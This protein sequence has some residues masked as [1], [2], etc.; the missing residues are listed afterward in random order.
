MDM[1]SNLALGLD[2]AFAPINL[3]ST[4]LGCL[5]GTLVGVLPGMGTVAILAMLLPAI[6]ALPPLAALSMLAGVYYGAPYG[7]ATAALWVKQ[8]GATGSVLTRIDGY[9]M[10]RQ[11][12]A[13]PALAAAGLGAFLAGCFGTLVLAA[14][15]PAL[16][17]LAFQLEPTEY[18][19][20]MVLALVGAGVLA[21]GALLKALAMGVLGLLLGLV[22]T[23]VHFGLARFA[24]DVPELSDGIGVVT[25]AMGVFAYG[26]V[27]SKLA[28]SEPAREVFT[29]Q[30]PD[31]WPTRQDLKDMA[32]AVLRGSALGSLLGMAPGG[33]A[34]LASFAAY[35]LEKKVQSRPGEVP[36]GKGNIRGVAAPEAARNA[37]AQTA[38]TA[39]LAL[40]IPPNAALAL[41]VGALS[42]HHIPPGPQLLTSNPALFW[43][44]IVSLCLG[45]LMLWVLHLPRIG[46]WN[47]LLSVPYRW[48][49]PAVVLLCAMGVYSSTHSRFDIWLV[50]AFGLV[51]YVFAKLDMAPAPLLLGFI[52]GPMMEESLRLALLQSGGDWSVFVTRPLSA[53]LL[54]AALCMVALVL[55]PAVQS[56][57]KA[58]FLEG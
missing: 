31:L 9:Q 46:V 52:L 17:P 12:R 21:S 19:A 33:G 36:L 47:K 45:R 24:F 14:L 50:A 3:L 49:F 48:L 5:L 20:L 4:L 1:I 51:G 2:A 55:L 15:V 53:G 37:G 25:L 26:E 29:A 38:F 54:A 28:Q 22:G 40:G 58:A 27:I 30:V 32:P 11:G 39:L 7:A 44:L 42:V 10:V 23:D 8:T 16:T 13:G 56:R 6:Y 57:R 18:F 41:V 34:L 43:G 35:A